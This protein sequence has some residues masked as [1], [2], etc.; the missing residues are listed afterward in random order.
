MFRNSVIKLCFLVA[1]LYQLWG[2]V[3]LNSQFTDETWK[4]L[5]EQPQL[6][7]LRNTSP[8]AT[9][10]QTKQE[11]SNATKTKTSRRILDDS[12]DFQ[13][14]YPPPN[15]RTSQQPKAVVGNKSVPVK[16]ATP[17]L[18]SPSSFSEIRDACFGSNS[19]KWIFG[20]ISSNNH[21]GITPELLDTLMEGPAHVQKLPSLFDQ[22][23]CHQ[24][25]PLRN[26]S[27]RTTSDDRGSID[28]LASVEDWY[29]RFL[30]LA[31]HWKFHRPALNEYRSRKRC[32]E[33][34]GRDGSLSLQSFMDHH[35]IGTMDFECKDE[36]FVI[37][38]VG[39]VGFG[40]LLNT[41]ASLSILL[42][43]RTN[44]I[45]IFSSRSYFYWQ[46]RKGDQDPWLLAPSNC[47][48]KDMQCYFL[49]ITPCT[50]T[51]EE[52]EKA[53]LYGSTRQ[54]QQFLR[55][56]VAI[57]PEL[58]KERVI[59]LNSGLSGKTI[60]TP[61]MREI[62]HGVVGKLMDEWKKAQNEGG[63]LSRSDQDW[64]AIHLAH[65][66]I[67]E[68]TKVD[69][70]GLLHQVYVYLLRPNPHYKNLLNRQMSAIGTQR[71]H[72]SETV[73]FAIRGSDKCKSESTCLPFYRYMEFV[74]DIAYPALRYSS[75]IRTSTD[76]DT[77]PKLIM[78]TEDPKIFNDSLAYQHNQSFPFQFLVNDNDNMQGSGYPREFAS[79]EEEKTIVSSLVALQLHFNAGKVYLNCCSNF[80]LVLKY[81]L[82]GQ[83]GARR[84]GHD[85]VFAT[86]TRNDSAPA[87]TPVAQCL[88]D[89]GFPKK[90]RICCNWSK[91][92]SVCGEIWKEYLMEK[93]KNNLLPKTNVAA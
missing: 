75:N 1:V 33:D 76:S 27:A 15:T 32:V 84:H 34:N 59:V 83:C 19:D 31:L 22:T 54:E 71:I 10:L 25:S 38:P 21:D 79:G 42:A 7:Q 87:P 49:P 74:T 6:G 90:Y 35:G 48:R 92:N 72:P 47:S 16:L 69:P 67:I 8:N 60:D 9:I 66:W 89:D 51:N 86:N 81:L 36:K 55:T 68:K 53:P 56:N 46:K 11:G 78:T 63:D 26:F 14:H 4:E 57:P 39:S 50:V 29:Q 91:K 18:A 58:E 30:Y 28:Y 5:S 23:I 17:S 24:D 45:P 3:R 93:E 62:S 61:D 65:Q 2:M 88:S 77:R 70:S 13:S 43:L 52:L 40:A 80:H 64:E 73:G 20:N 44:R 41:Q 12:N 85:F 82:H 37:I